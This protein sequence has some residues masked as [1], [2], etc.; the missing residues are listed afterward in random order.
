MAILAALYLIL[1][2]YIHVLDS[3]RPTA[4]VSSFGEE[5]PVA[6]YLEEDY[7]DGARYRSER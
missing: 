5:T 6:M 4:R 3:S 7:I 2:L 1:S